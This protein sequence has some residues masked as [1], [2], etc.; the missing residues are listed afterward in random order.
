MKVGEFFVDMGINATAGATT[1]KD[2]IGSMGR[3]RLSTLSTIG[4]LGTVGSYIM[5]IVD[6]SS[7]AAVSF[8]KFS[9]QTGLSSQELQRWQIVAKQANVSAGDIAGS[10]QNLQSKLATI[11]LTGQGVKPFQI[12]GISPLGNAFD[13]LTKLRQKMGQVSPDVF[14]NLI[15]EM[16]LS[17]DMVNVLK[18]SDQEFANFVSTAHGMSPQIETNVLKMTEAFNKLWLKIKDVNYEIANFA[19][20]PISMA[21]S[22]VLKN[23][24]TKTLGSAVGTG[25]KLG[26]DVLTSPFRQMDRLVSAV[27]ADM[28]GHRL[29]T[30]HLAISVTGDTKDVSFAQQVAE[31]VVNKLTGMVNET[32]AQMPASE[33]QTPR[34]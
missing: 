25:A 31:L 34:K 23:W 30:N 29:Q 7:N 17:P 12:L 16:G 26:T 2:F 28:T 32:E 1:L 20:G 24:D 3:M 27:A 18:L 11:R 15:Q 6:Q 5:G 8:Q 33:S 4:A 9:N 10:I 19:S 14:T 21:L 13:I 22:E